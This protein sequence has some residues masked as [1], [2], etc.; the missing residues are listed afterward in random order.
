MTDDEETSCL[1]MTMAADGADNSVIGN[2]QQENHLI[3]VNDTDNQKI[4]FQAIQC[5]TLG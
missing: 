3:I 4:S 1:P 5:D 2:I